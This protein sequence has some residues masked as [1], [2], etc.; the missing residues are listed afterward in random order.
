M[1]LVLITALQMAANLKAQIQILLKNLQA[2]VTNKKTSTVGAPMMK[3]PG[4]VTLGT[5]YP[6]VFFNVTVN[7]TSFFS[8]TFMVDTLS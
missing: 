6:F 4:L 5:L 1:I 3:Y 8:L 7:G 2:V